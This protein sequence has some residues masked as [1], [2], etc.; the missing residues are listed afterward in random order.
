MYNTFFYS[1][2]MAPP[3]AMGPWSIVLF[4]WS[5]LNYTLYDDKNLQPFENNLEFLGRKKPFR[6][7]QIFLKTHARHRARFA[8]ERMWKTRHA[9]L[10]F[11]MMQ[12]KLA[13]FSEENTTWR[14]ERTDKSRSLFHWKMAKNIS[15]SAARLEITFACSAARST[16]SIR[17][18]G[19]AS[20]RL[21][22]ERK[23]SPWGLATTVWRQMSLWFGFRRWNK[24][25]KGMTRNT[26]R[27][28]TYPSQTVLSLPAGSLNVAWHLGYLRRTFC[29]TPLII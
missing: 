8:R 6:F 27:R 22:S 20:H 1:L 4:I 15:W 14:F 17:R 13:L 23:L 9:T 5:C 11:P 2:K 25:S 10:H 16:R 26:R 3:L 24:Y 29:P 12:H 19:D 21:T 18:Y 7:S 28:S